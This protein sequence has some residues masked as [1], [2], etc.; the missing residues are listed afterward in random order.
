MM[1]PLAIPDS[2]AMEKQMKAEVR[3]VSNSDRRR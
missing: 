1:I 2:E 3:G